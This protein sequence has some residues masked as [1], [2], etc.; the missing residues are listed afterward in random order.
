MIQQLFNKNII[1]Y[2]F[3]FSGARKSLFI[4]IIIFL[5]FISAESTHSKMFAYRS[6][7]N[8]SHD[9]ASK[10]NDIQENISS[11]Q[12]AINKKLDL[13]EIAKTEKNKE[14]I[15]AE[16][17][18]IRDAISEQEISFEMIIT[19]GIELDTDEATIKKDF[20]WQQDLLDIVQPF[21]TE[22]HHLTENKRKLDLLH[23]K[24]NFYQEQIEKI[25][26]AILHISQFNREGLHSSTEREMDEILSKWKNH[27]K[28]FTHLLQIA[29]L[30]RQEMIQSKTEEE[31]SLINQLE[32]FAAGRGV[33][34]LLAVFA[35]ISVYALM[36]FFLRIFNWIISRGQRKRSYYQRLINLLYHLL[37]IVLA[38]S[39]LFYVLDMRDDPLLIAITFIILISIIWILK[40]SLPTYID[41]FRLLLNTGSA[42]EGECIVYNSM[43]LLIENIQ[44]Y[45]NLINPVLP[46]VKLRLTL[47]ELNKYVSR[48]VT[49]DEPWFPCIKG[50]YVMLYGDIYGMVKNITLE[51]IVL[52]LPDGTMP[53]TYTIEDFFIA[54]PRNYSLGFIV[55]S[56]FG[57]HYKHQEESATHIPQKLKSEIEKNIKHAEYGS[58]LKNLSVYLAKSSY[59]LLEYHILAQFEGKAASEYH[60]ILR[61]LQRH[62]VE[63]CNQNQWTIITLEED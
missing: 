61:D 46:D 53:I 57:I 58:F 56:D 13:L 33:T 31:T 51:S 14:K 19:A 38:I 44:Y 12:K 8:L 20:D 15:Q 25:N 42:R 35:F 7:I 4:Y 23:H 32:E 26:K 9:A 40:N 22:L 37:M 34:L 63:A 49:T 55:Q 54:N 28:E 18:T 43:P 59:S 50:D 6:D 11:Q 5:L 1:L 60:Q 21:I 52:S 48:P 36:L 3:N 24:I 27:L 29:Q 45:S 41:E 39:A 30:Q 62:A 17:D 2:L 47:A 10:L 16:I